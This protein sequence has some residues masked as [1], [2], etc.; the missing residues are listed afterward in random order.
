MSKI[1]VLEEQIFNQIAAGEVVERPVNV[2]KECVE[3]SIDSGATQITVEITN[4]GIN[5]IKIVDNG[6]GIETDD[7]V[8]AFK[9][10][11]TSKLKSIDDL[12]HVATLGFRGEALS[13]IASVTKVTLISKTKDSDSAYTMYG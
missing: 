9:P 7:F 4:A 1:N 5:Q 12:E 11:A 2:V 8:K 13:S 6:C 10:H 3:N